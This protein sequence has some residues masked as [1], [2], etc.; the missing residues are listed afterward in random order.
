MIQIK[1]PGGF[2]AIFL[3][4][5]GVDDLEIFHVVARVG[6]EGTPPKWVGC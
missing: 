6:A 5:E 3:A 1:C 4:G 2:S